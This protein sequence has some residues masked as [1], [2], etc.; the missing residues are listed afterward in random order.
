MNSDIIRDAK[1]GTSVQN[2]SKPYIFIRK[3]EKETGRFTRAL[4][5]V[6]QDSILDIRVPVFRSDGQLPEIRSYMEHFPFPFYVILRD[7]E[8]LPHIL[9]DALRQWFELVT[10]HDR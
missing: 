5:A 2:G 6:L 10:S 4:F 3:T 8:S 9:G 1:I 7:I